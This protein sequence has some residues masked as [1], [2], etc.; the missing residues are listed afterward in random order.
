MAGNVAEWCNDWYERDYY[1][2]SPGADPQGP[3]SGEKKVLRGGG[4]RSTAENCTSAIRL[5][6]D[7]G[8]TDA[9]IASDDFGFRCVRRA[10]GK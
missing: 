7:P 6:D 8:F 10:G 3:A 1:A 9:C 2:Q 5:N 4:F